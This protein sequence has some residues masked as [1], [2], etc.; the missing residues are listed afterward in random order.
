MTDDSD[1]TL[2]EMI[3]VL[4]DEV[5]IDDEQTDEQ[6]DRVLKEILGPVDVYTEGEGPEGPWRWKSLQVVR[7]MN[8]III[9]DVDGVTTD[10]IWVPDATRDD[11]VDDMQE[12]LHEHLDQLN[13]KTLKRL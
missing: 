10:I 5:D 6:R 8:R 1:K 4:K 2:E 13:E 12:A 11:V 3:E 9:R 7:R